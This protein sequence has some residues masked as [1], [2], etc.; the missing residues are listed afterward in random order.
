MRVILRLTVAFVSSN[1]IRAAIGFATAVLLARQLGAADFGRWTLCMAIASTLT[2]AL[3]LGFGVLL[4][5]DAAR[6]S[7]GNAESAELAENSY[8][9]A[10]SAGSA[11]PRD[12]LTIGVEVSNALLA[13]LGLLAPV[14]VIVVI[15]TAPA[16][17]AGLAQ[18]I[19]T[20]V[21]L[22]AAGVAYGCLS[23]AL[24]GWPEWLVPV[25]AVETGGA[26]LQ[27]AGTW[28]IAGHGGGVVALLWL[29]T[30]VQSAQILAAAIL[31]MLSRDRH[32][33]LVMPTPARAVALV[34]RSIPFALSGLIANVHVRLAPLALGLFAGVEQVALFGAAQRFASLV[35]MLPQSAFGGA[36][37][38]LSREAQTGRGDRVRGSFER[39]IAA[40]AVA[41]AAGL[42]L[43]APFVV[44]I[45]YGRSFQGAAPVLVWLALALMPT[46]TNNARQ[47][48]LYAAGRERVATIWSGVALAAQAA[49]CVLL[50]PPFGAAGAAIAVGLAEALVWWPLR[51]SQLVIQPVV[52]LGGPVG[53]VAENPVAS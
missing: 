47:L 19:A 42:A 26:V 3:D 30:A 7:R 14:A 40:F 20:A 12:T 24:R 33:S 48:S 31:W 49:G 43:L 37:P 28:W 39:A 1:A 21:L 50:I 13:R 8:G 25:L 34:R 15:A 36:L 52:S 27:L 41:S 44:R 4:T 10:D 35:K 17:A 11:F 18:G 16:D 45:A 51:R 29:A 53:V 23:A 6:E 22:A 46:L 32:D 5:R 38:V 2:A 9:K